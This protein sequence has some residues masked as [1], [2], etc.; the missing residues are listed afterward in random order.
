MIIQ[1]RHRRKRKK[2]RLTNAIT[3]DR[4]G[5]K[6]DTV[7]RSQRARRLLLEESKL[8]ERQESEREREFVAYRG[9]AS[10]TRNWRNAM[11]VAQPSGVDRFNS[12]AYGLEI[13]PESRHPPFSNPVRHYRLQNRNGGGV[14]A[15]GPRLRPSQS[16]RPICVSVISARQWTTLYIIAAY[17]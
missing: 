6:N 11:V 2:K 1:S 3:G 4:K 12:G 15:R 5:T 13:R 14:A 8:S 9:R 10:L 16:H 7:Y 17:G